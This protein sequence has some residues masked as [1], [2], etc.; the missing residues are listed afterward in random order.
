MIAYYIYCL[1]NDGMFVI[2]ISFINGVSAMGQ[3][4][5]RNIPDDQY[6]AL[7]RVAADNNRSAEAEVRLAISNLVQTRGGFGSKLAAKYSGAIEANFEFGRD[8]TVSKPMD[9]E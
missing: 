8:Q 3:M 7:K 1:H 6:E 2:L 9:F 4:T 5:V